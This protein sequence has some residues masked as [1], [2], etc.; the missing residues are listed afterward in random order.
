VCRGGDCLV[1]LEQRAQ[2]AQRAVA[3]RQPRHLRCHRV[4][5]H[6]YLL[7]GNVISQ[8]TALQC[9]RRDGAVSVS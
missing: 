9:K 3:G 5:R 7:L 2:R 4:G 8:I 6:N 1:I